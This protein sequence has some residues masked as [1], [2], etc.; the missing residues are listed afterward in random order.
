MKSLKTIAIAVP[1]T[2]LVLWGLLA[3]AQLWA[4]VVS[5]KAFEKLT[6][7]AAIVIVISVITSI[8]IRAHIENAKLK[9]QGYLDSN[10]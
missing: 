8:A 4:S 10:D 3:L 7:S 9:E 2:T 5:N 6:A 1:L